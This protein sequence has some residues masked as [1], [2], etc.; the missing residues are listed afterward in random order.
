METLMQLIAKDTALYSEPQWSVLEGGEYAAD[1][2][3]TC[4]RISDPTQQCA[5]YAIFITTGEYP[6]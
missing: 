1:D 5:F 6:E 4:Y 3:V 2:L